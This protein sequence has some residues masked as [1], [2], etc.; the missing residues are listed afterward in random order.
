MQ[1]TENDILKRVRKIEIKTRG[2]SN[3][4]FAGKY[5]TAF[6]GRGMS[7]S[8]VREYRAGDDVRD[9][10]WN[11]TARSRTPH[12]KVYEEER[13]LTM[14]L[15]VD[16]SGSRMF[17][18]TDRL[19][20]N[21]QTEIAAVLAFSASEN[22]DKVGCIFFSDRIEKFI[23]PK[24]GRSHILAI[25]RELVGFEPQSRGTRISEAL[26]FLTNVTKK[27]CTAF[28]LSD[29]LDPGKDRTALEDALK[30]ASGKHDLVG[31]R[32]SDPR[33]AELPDVGI[34]EMKDAET[35]RKAWVDTSSARV[36]EHYARVWQERSAAILSAL[37]HHRIDIQTAMKSIPN[38]PASTCSPFARNGGIQPSAA[39]ERQ[40]A[41]QTPPS[42][43]VPVGLRSSGRPK[44]G[45]T[46]ITKRVKTALATALLTGL[47][48]VLYAA[49]P[50][51]TARVE[52]DSIGIGDRFDVVIDVDRDLVQ[53]VEF[54][55]F[56]PPPQSGLE[57]VES[58]PV[59]TLRRDGRHLSLRKRY[60]LAAFEEGNLGLG[61]AQVLYL[62]KN[63][64]DTLYTA[65]TL[66]LQV[67][68]F[69]IDST[70][71]TIYDIKAQRTLPFRYGEISGYVLWSLLGLIVL[72][73][74][75]YA[76]RRL[77]ARYARKVRD[78]FR[79]APPLPPHI[80][81]IQ[82]LE[83]LHNQKLW[84]SGR[85]KQYYSGLTDILRTY[86]AGRYGFGAMEMT[87]DEI[88]AAVRRYD[89]PQKCVMDLQAILRDADLAKFAKAQSEGTTNEDNY[90]NAYYFVEE[91]KPA[92]I[93]EEGTEQD[94]TQ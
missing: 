27:H 6:R 38:N 72:G 92:E 71:H 23:P 41:A 55:T 85:H 11:V 1:E 86:L 89:L 40:N 17:G 79:P 14:M 77:M 4:I 81:A 26:R 34:V 15:L 61:R 63:I 78:I 2:L 67:G 64:T 62:D 28:L 80:A 37:K 75:I 25:I 84:Q 22:N 31:I 45:R 12:I 36:R 49:P 91:T 87:S 9:I 8:E 19:K 74:A 52:P 20:K 51:I 73:G 83:T 29:F 44:A 46:S 35:G 56:N 47:T 58:H 82:A 65:D 33:E 13:E 18:T 24:K 5:H 60:T 32:V 50:T 94:D 16:V 3:E 68:T 48:T 7:F 57:V 76:G 10:D 90:L 93:A 42:E 59:D 69:Q 21:L 88:L 43:A 30:I 53:V 39:A 70:S 66:R 54:P